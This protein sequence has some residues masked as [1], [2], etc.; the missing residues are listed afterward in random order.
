MS[1]LPDFAD[2]RFRTSVLK[3]DFRTITRKKRNPEPRE[4]AWD[5]VAQTSIQVSGGS[6]LNRIFGSTQRMELWLRGRGNGAHL[7]AYPDLG[8]SAR[9]IPAYTSTQENAREGVSFAG[10]STSRRLSPLPLAN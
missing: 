5:T 2:L 10:V 4:E 1:W 3:S 7:P 6:H 9:I 8:F